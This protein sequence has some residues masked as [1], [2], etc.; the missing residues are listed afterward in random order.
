MSMDSRFRNV[1][2]SLCRRRF[3]QSRC[4]AGELNRR[5]AWFCP[6]CV[7]PMQAGETSAAAV[8]AQSEQRGKKR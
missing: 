2:C 7:A 5:K 8:R 6:Y 4:T 1:E 3:P